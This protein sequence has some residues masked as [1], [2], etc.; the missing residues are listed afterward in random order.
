METQYV[1]DEI[2]VYP[3]NIGPPSPP[4]TACCGAYF[5]K[6]KIHKKSNTADIFTNP[7]PAEAQ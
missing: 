3:S 6:T 1:Y 4:G 2:T 7:L 5:T